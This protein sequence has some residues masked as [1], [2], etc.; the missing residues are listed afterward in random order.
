MVRLKL[1]LLNLVLQLAQADTVPE[2]VNE[3]DG[4]G[5]QGKEKGDPHVGCHG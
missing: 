2:Q 3:D 5:E 1:E 4:K